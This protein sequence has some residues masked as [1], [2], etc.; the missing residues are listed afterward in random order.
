MC[1]NFAPLVEELDLLVVE[2]KELAAA[3]P[4]FRIL[5]RFQEAVVDCAPGEEVTF[6]SLL[7]H[8]REYPLRLSLALRILFDYLARHRLPQSATQIEA[9]IGT[10]AFYVRHGANAK[11]SS[12]LTRKISRRG[13]KEYVKRIR[14]A[15]QNTFHEA[16]LRLDPSEVLVSEPTE[17]NE[18]N[19]R[20]K[21]SCEWIH[22]D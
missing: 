16:G 14:R 21:A 17:S 9:G 13:V 22:V 6:V 1:D 12:K 5:H 2:I 8:S 19:Y 11:T 4:H 20:L 3:G 15:L 18:V 7:Y 10:D